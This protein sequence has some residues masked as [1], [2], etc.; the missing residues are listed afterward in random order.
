MTKKKS[1]IIVEQF[2]QGITVRWKDVDGEAMPSKSLAVV[3][4]EC[5]V[6]GK[7]IWKSV[8]EILSDT[9]TDRVRVKIECEALVSTL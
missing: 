7:E 9:S 1:E 5:G 6:I 2:A 4:T 3:G 8:S